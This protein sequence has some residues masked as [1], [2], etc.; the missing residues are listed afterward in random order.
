MLD[1]VLK[2]FKNYPTEE[3]TKKAVKKNE[4]FALDLQREQLFSG[5]TSRNTPIT[6]QYAASTR[7]TKQRKGQPTNRVTWRA[8]GRLYAELELKLDNDGFGPISPNVATPFLIARYGNQ[9]LGFTKESEGK[10]SE[11]I[12]PD[13]QQETKNYFTK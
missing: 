3:I 4:E 9:V 7:R 13:L 2:L 5:T 1:E 12:L 6:P 10:I 8:T 11:K